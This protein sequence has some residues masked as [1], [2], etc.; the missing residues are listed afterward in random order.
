MPLCIIRNYVLCNKFAWQE[1]SAIFI[2]KSK[3]GARWR[4]RASG[5]R[6]LLAW[7]SCAL[8]M[9]IYMARIGIQYDDV[10]GAID[11]LMARGESP[12]VQKIREVLGTG[13][14]TTISDHLREWRSR[15]EM[16]TDLPVSQVMPEP[17]LRLA[18]SLWERAREAS[19]E[20]L[21]QYRQEADRQV[22]AA[23]AAIQEARRQAEDAEQRE[24]ALTAH[25]AGTEQR[26]EARS[27]ALARVESECEQWQERARQ[28]EERLSRTLQQLDKLQQD[29]EQQAQAHQQA[30]AERDAQH[31][32]RLNQEEQRHEAAEARLM[33]LLDEAR[34]ERIAAEKRHAATL[35]QVEKRQE[36]LLEQLQ[37]AQAALSREEKQRR[38]AQWAKSRAEE[39]IDT[40]RH[41]Q[42][43]LQARID[44]QKRF[45]DEQ[46]VR[47]RSL[48]A[49]LVRRTWQQ[50]KEKG[51]V[52]ASRVAE[53]VV[54]TLK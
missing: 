53:E 13:S 49:E 40:L 5:S 37:E 17:V 14:F 50:D 8:F 22:E 1:K 29:N 20:A 21:A 34:Q 24:A 9:E 38:E 18:E 36:T 25:L 43:L 16:K 31:Q 12:S 11:V 4:V 28:V 15:R 41:E 44:D 51:E 23:Q 33:T 26:L 30:L 39:R 52:L 54:P 10:R 2:S 48:E 42:S 47:L 46:A 6:R 19:G 35:Q 27:A 3:A 45:S 7:K 32:T